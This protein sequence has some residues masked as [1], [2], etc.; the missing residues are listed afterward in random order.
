MA[1]GSGGPAGQ[2]IPSS[3]RRGWVTRLADGATSWLG[4]RDLWPTTKTSLPPSVPLNVEAGTPEE[5]VRLLYE[6]AFE[7]LTIFLDWRHKTMTIGFTVLAAAIALGE[8]L[9]K[10][11]KQH[12]TLAA[13]LFAAALFCVVVR[14]FDQR[15]QTILN[16]AYRVGAG[17]ERRLGARS[18]SVMA[19]V[20]RSR[21]RWTYHET[22]KVVFKWTAVVCALTGV[23]AVMWSVCAAGIWSGWKLLI[24]ATLFSV[25]VFAATR[26][27]LDAT[28]GKQAAAPAES[29]SSPETV[30]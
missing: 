29:A 24:G 25:V 22:I 8:W 20:P 15:N 3:P 7:M 4:D 11:Q 17:L 21:P 14:R 18:G 26:R 12:W 1:I 19:G 30:T 2:Q 23:A 27:G 9:L 6:K 16:D 28:N 10:N 13:P 5:N